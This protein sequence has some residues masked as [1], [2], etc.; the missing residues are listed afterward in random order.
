MQLV[1]AIAL[2]CEFRQHA[3]TQAAAH[4]VVLVVRTVRNVI[5]QGDA[6]LSGGPIVWW[7]LGLTYIVSYHI[8]TCGAVTAHVRTDR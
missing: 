8:S 6:P 3:R 4:R 7:K 2:L 5:N 1:V